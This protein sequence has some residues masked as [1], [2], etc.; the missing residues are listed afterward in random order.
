MRNRIDKSWIGKEIEWDS[1]PDP[2][3][4]WYDTRSGILIAIKGRNVIVD[5]KGNHEWLWVPDMYNIRLKD[6]PCNAKV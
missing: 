2:H 1:K 4:G 6:K 5:C 3:R